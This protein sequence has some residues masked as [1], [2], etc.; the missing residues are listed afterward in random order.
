MGFRAPLL[1]PFAED[2]GHVRRGHLAS[3]ATAPGARSVPPSPHRVGICD[4]DKPR[5]GTA[6]EK[7]MPLTLEFDVKQQRE[8]P[9]P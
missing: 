3:S 5:P 4:G 6:A 9:R 2:R 7:P 1:K 8:T